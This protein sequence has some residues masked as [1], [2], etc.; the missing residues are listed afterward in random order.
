MSFHLGTTGM[1]DWKHLT[2][3]KLLEHE[4]SS[5]HCTNQHSWIECSTRLLQGSCVDAALQEQHLPDITLYL[6]G[7]GLAF[8]GSSDRLFTTQNG[9]FLGLIIE[10]LGK[11][12]DIVKK[13]L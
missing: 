13:H 7:R 3:V 5:A 8:R 2:Q 6:S 12:E 11:Y 10:L 9:T 4:S 1:N